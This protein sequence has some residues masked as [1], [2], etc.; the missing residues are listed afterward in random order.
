MSAPTESWQHW[1]PWKVLSWIRIQVM[2]ESTPRSEPA[3]AV[4]VRVGLQLTLLVTAVPGL[5]V[6]IIALFLVVEL[7]VAALAEALHHD[8]IPGGARHVGVEPRE[9]RPE[10]KPRAGGLPRVNTTY[11]NKKGVPSA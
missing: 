7:Q 5:H 6:A 4:A 9:D 8:L 10:S 11:Y 2:R 1:V 3:H